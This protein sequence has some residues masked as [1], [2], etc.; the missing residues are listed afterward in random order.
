MKK[1]KTEKLF[2]TYYQQHPMGRFGPV[3]FSRSL[4]TPCYC[5]QWRRVH[6]SKNL[7]ENK[8]INHY[9]DGQFRWKRKRTRSKQS[10]LASKSLQN[11]DEREAHLRHGVSFL[12]VR[13][14][15][16]MFER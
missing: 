14:A 8:I 12:S 13:N 1:H 11:G 10:V 6:C 9:R 2:S 3:L 7:K 4:R 16:F 15:I 5:R